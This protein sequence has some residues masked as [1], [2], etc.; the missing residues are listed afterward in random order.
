MAHNTSTVSISIGE[1]QA[2]LENHT[3]LFVALWLKKP[4]WC[5]LCKEF[6]KDPF[7]PNAAECKL[8]HTQVHLSCVPE[9]KHILQKTWFH[10]PTWCG[11][12]KDFIANPLNP[13]G[14]VCVVCD[15][16]ICLSC[17]K[18]PEFETKKANK[19]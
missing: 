14:K 6:I 18:L 8:C 1:H 12:C 2:F 3:H 4:T 7:D 11:N 17:A 10:K 15:H 13:N 16:K 5:G 19:K 9:H